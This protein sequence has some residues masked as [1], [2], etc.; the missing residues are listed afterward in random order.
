MDLSSDVRAACWILD[1]D[2]GMPKGLPVFQT[3]VECNSIPSRSIR[4]ASLAA[5]LAS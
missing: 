5:S 2:S 3:I 4:D 1:G